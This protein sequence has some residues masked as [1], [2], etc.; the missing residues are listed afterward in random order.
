MTLTITASELKRFAP[1]AKAVYVDTLLANLDVLKDAGILENNFR[2]AHFFAQV[3]AET[4]GM[5]ILRESMAYRTP[6]RLRAVWPSRFGKKSDAFLLDLIEDP[7]KL[8]DSVYGGRMGNKKG[9]SDGF[10]FR[11]GGYL[12]TTGRYAVEAYCKKLGVDPKLVPIALDDL[13]LCLQMACL[14]W[15]ESGCNTWADQNDILKVSKAINTGSATSNVMPVGLPDRKHWLGQSLKIW[16]QARHLADVADVQ[17][18]KLE[19]RTIAAAGLMRK[20]GPVI[21]AAAGAK[22]ANDANV[23]VPTP[24]AVDI[25]LAEI[26]SQLSLTQKVMEGIGA[27]AKFATSNYWIAGLVIG[28]ILWLY[29][30]K[31]IAWYLE[32]IR[33]GKRTALLKSGGK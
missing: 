23:P 7:V 26:A 17:P 25:P 18:D 13:T 28:A 14:E 19:S 11:G 1:K 31:I 22:G 21:A 12:Q 4:D 9:T 20:A 6:A 24:P 5:T 29:G 16:G 27:V 15:E 10:D 32:D 2:L 33:T 30:G 3:G 8:A